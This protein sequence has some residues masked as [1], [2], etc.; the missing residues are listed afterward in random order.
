MEV[1]EEKWRGDGDR[2]ER[3]QKS[4]PRG[5][6]NEREGVRRKYNVVSRLG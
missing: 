5:L 3:Y 6:R 1:D 4:E 2:R